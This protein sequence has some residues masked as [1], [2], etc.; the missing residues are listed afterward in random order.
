MS[1]N[2]ISPGW[3]AVSRRVN[4]TPLD[5]AGKSGR[6]SRMSADMLGKTGSRLPHHAP[7]AGEDD[8]V[9]AGRR[10]ERNG[11][12]GDAAGAAAACP[13]PAMDAAKDGP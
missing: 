5:G 3:A 9:I 7:D 11:P 6:D 12:Y 4:P 1:G 8:P 2:R 10:L 13:P